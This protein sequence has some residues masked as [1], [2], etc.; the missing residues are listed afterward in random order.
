MVINRN[1]YNNSFSN[2]YL[3]PSF[4]ALTIIIAVPVVILIWRLKVKVKSS[5]EAGESTAFM[6]EIWKL[7]VL[8]ILFSISFLTRWVFDSY[9][10]EIWMP[11]STKG[12]EGDLLCP[13]THGVMMICN[14]YN[15]CMIILTTQFVWDLI[16]IGA[17]L[18]FH[19]YSF[20]DKDESEEIKTLIDTKDAKEIAYANLEGNSNF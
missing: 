19:H 20:R 8:M 10:I 1:N 2:N 7:I 16:P 6:S 15:R 13:D 14:P 9:L 18:L 11:P 4:L 17:I 3:G 12:G 5:Q